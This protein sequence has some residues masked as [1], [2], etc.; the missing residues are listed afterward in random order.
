MKLSILE[1]DDGRTAKEYKAAV[2][3]VKYRDAWL[4]GLAQNTGDDR[5]NHWV[6]PGG[7]IKS[8]EAPLKAAER[9]AKEETGIRCSAHGSIITHDGKRDVAF[10]AC[11]AE[12]GQKP[13]PNHEFSHLGFFTPKQME[14]LDLY[15]NVK[16]LLSKAKRY[17]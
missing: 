13:K 3:I 11:K 10:V 2:A 4:L 5:D 9:E 7:H 1:A 16:Q 6:F 15:R 17:L 8:G 12:P 14:S